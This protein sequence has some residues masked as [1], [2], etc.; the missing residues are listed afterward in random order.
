[1][2]HHHET[3]LNGTRFQVIKSLFFFLMWTIFKVFIESVTIL[4]LFYA[5]VVFGLTTCRILAPRPGIKSEPPALEGKVSTTG[6]PGTFLSLPILHWPNKTHTPLRNFQVSFGQ[7][8]LGLSSTFPRP[9]AFCLFF[10]LEFNQFC[11][12]LFLLW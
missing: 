3:S 12:V 8:D 11:P 2:E 4:L 6:P 7:R 5:L 10:Y 1:M 9:S